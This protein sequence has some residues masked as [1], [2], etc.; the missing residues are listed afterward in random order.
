MDFY[1]ISILSSLYTEIVSITGNII[2]YLT[3]T[4]FYSVLSSLFTSKVEIDTP[5]KP[6]RIIHQKTTGNETGAEIN[7]K[8][9]SRINK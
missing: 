8:T 2:N 5:T 6:V 7:S 3:N 4:H 9:E 1:G